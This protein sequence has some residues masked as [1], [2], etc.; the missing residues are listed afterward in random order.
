MTAEHVSF[1]VQM[2]YLCHPDELRHVGVRL[3]LMTEGT[4]E[5]FQALAVTRGREAGF[6]KPRLGIT[7]EFK[8]GKGTDQPYPV[9]TDAWEVMVGEF[10]EYC[11]AE[12]E[13][14]AYDADRYVLPS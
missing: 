9:S 11:R 1:G 2:N 3:G 7:M 10:P 6:T 4:Y 8:G 14:Y 12:P 5:S 13:V